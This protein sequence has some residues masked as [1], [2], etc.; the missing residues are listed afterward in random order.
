MAKGKFR[1]LLAIHLFE[2][3]LDL[4]IRRTDT[5]ARRKPAIVQAIAP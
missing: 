3:L 1:A 5:P 2:L 4:G